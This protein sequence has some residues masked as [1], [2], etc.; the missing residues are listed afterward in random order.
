MGQF[1]LLPQEDLD[2]LLKPK[3]LGF[4]QEPPPVKTTVERY[5]DHDGLTDERVTQVSDSSYTQTGSPDD[6]GATGNAWTLLTDMDDRE[7]ALLSKAD[8]IFKKLK[9]QDAV[10]GTSEADAFMTKVLQRLKLDRTNAEDTA[11]RLIAQDFYTNQSF[12]E[13][14]QNAA[15]QGAT[16]EQMGKLSTAYHANN[17]AMGQTMQQA[18]FIAQQ[19]WNSLPED[20]KYNQLEQGVS[21]GDWVNRAAADLMATW[22]TTP[23]SK[24]EIKEAEVETKGLIDINKKINQDIYQ[25]VMDPNRVYQDAIVDL[26]RIDHALAIFDSGTV[27][28]G[29]LARP[30]MIF[31]RFIESSFAG[32]SDEQRKLIAET[33]KRTSGISDINVR[34]AEYLDSLFTLLG[35]RNI[36]LTKGNVTEREMLMFLKIAPELSKS[37]EGNR[38]LLQILRNINLKIISGR[39]AALR[40]VN[41]FGWPSDAK[42]PKSPTGFAQW[43]L[44]Q[45]EV[46][47][48]LKYDEE[49][50]GGIIP[51]EAKDLYFSLDKPTAGIP[52]VDGDW[53][54]I[55]GAIGEFEEFSKVDTPRPFRYEGRLFII[56]DGFMYEVQMNE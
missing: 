14:I 28:T 55:S 13:I 25:F 53:S 12:P 56:K 23:T 39:Q 46:T 29:P 9:G 45:P 33:R 49:G 8:E 11:D 2:E 6:S 15:N 52:S 47:R 31:K 24:I 54:V 20:E 37:V 42:G 41:M 32:G 18:L 4:L 34:D 36:Q 16:I 38:L 51:Q 3:S 1:S 10:L 19:S 48:W 5:T 26:Q 7:K 44:E 43:M 21:Q 50:V 27:Q 40:Y 22:Q 35:A 17:P 30:M